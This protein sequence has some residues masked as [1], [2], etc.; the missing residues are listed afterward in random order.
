MVSSTFLKDQE[1]NLRLISKLKPTL[2]WK[3]DIK[4]NTSFSTS[5]SGRL[6]KDISQMSCRGISRTG[7]PKLQLLALPC[8]SH[9]MQLLIT[10]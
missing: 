7:A 1:D 3:S 9:S 6:D 4:P 2:L 5:M 8:L 10:E